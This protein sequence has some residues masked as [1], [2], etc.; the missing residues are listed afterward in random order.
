MNN[1]LMYMYICFKF[2]IGLALCTSL[3]SKYK[4]WINM[5]FGTI[6]RVQMK[7]RI[8]LNYEDKNLKKKMHF[9]FKMIVK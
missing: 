4:L 9:V 6:F 1:Y 7:N 5:H 3:R 2:Y 8:V